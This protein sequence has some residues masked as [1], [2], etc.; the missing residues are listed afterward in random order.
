MND[1]AESVA[2][3]FVRA[4]NRQDVDALVE[5]MTAEHR[6]IDSMGNVVEDRDKM[7]AGWAKYFKMVPDYTVA[8]EETFCDGPV[9]VMLGH[10]A[11]DLLDRWKAQAREPLVNAYGFSRVH[12]GSESRGVACLLRQ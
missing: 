4:I 11:G 7:R 1:L 6:F 3:A 2:H 5:L 8:I 12:S 9:V 10:G